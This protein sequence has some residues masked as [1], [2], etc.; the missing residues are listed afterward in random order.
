M[1]KKTVAELGH[2]DLLSVNGFRFCQNA[3]FSKTCNRLV[4]FSQNDLQTEFFQ[5]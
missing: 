5:I 3:S 2:I 1:E 4:K